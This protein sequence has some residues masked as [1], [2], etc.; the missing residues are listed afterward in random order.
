MLQSGANSAYS[1]TDRSLLDVHMERVQHYLT[2]RVIDSI[3]QLDDLCSQVDETCFEPI[4]GFDAQYHSVRFG[5][6][7]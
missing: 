1:I 5:I 7:G 3:Y 4:K 2:S 6:F